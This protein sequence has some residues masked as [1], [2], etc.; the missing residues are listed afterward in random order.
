MPVQAETVE[1]LQKYFQGVTKRAN[2]HAHNVDEIIYSLLGIFILKKDPGTDLEV[3]GT[4]ENS[5]GNILW[6]TIKGTRYTCR[7][8]HSDGSIEIRQNSSSGPV[9][10]KVSNATSVKSI[11]SVF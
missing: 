7:Y 10:L 1:V 3:R 6:V 11:L 4:D 8:E 5:T 9:I 2:H